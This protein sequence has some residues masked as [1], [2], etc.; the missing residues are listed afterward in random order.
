LKLAYCLDTVP[1]VGAEKLAASADVL[2]ADSTFPHVDVEHAHETGHSTA[3][4]AANLAQKCGVQQLLLT[5]FSGKLTQD[6]LP[7]LV[8]EARAIFPNG[9][10]ATDLARFVIARRD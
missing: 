6:D 9:F 10:A 5:H 8:A 1:C 2:I 4:D 3:T 7:L